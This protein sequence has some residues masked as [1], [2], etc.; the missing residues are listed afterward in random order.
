MMHFYVM[1]ERLNG[2]TCR[3]KTLAASFTALSLFLLEE[4]KGNP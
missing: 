3:K 1:I 2:E 4:T